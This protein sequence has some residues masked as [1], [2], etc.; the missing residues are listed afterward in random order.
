MSSLSGIEN[1]E[2]SSFALGVN[3]KLGNA[4]SF[5][6][7]SALGSMFFESK[8]L[9]S[10]YADPKTTTITIPGLGTFEKLTPAGQLAVSVGFSNFEN[11]L[12]TLLGKVEFIEK[13][14][15]DKVFSL[16]S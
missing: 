10:D 2:L 5:D 1:K 12:S 13:T 11:A 9:L 15:A 8:N 16:L 4:G 14:F 3:S 7:K 6:F